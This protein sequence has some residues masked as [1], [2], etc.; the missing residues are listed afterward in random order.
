MTL[1]TISLIF[2]KKLL[3]HKGSPTVISFFLPGYIIS[4]KILLLKLEVTLSPSKIPVRVIYWFILDL[5]IL[6]RSTF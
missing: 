6:E 4:N 2:N 3:Q 5:I 1:F